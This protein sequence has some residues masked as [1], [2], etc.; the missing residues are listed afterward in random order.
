[1][2][3]IVCSFALQ[4]GLNAASLVDGRPIRSFV[5]FLHLVALSWSTVQSRAAF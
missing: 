5:R 1:L 2:I 3:R 4:L